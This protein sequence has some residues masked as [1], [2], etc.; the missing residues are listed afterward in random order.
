MSER[1][2]YRVP[3]ERKPFV[4]RTGPTANPSWGV[5]YGNHRWPSRSEWYVPGTWP[6]A[7]TLR[8]ESKP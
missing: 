1:L 2:A 7:Y 6:V 4:W 3:E 5:S 8:G